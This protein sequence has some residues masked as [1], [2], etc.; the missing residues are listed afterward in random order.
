MS[1]TAPS[2]RPG[3][4]RRGRSKRIG[5]AIAFG[6][7][8]GVLLF[9]GST[10]MAEHWVILPKPSRD[11]LVLSRSLAALHHDARGRFQLTHILYGECRCSQRIFDYLFSSARPADV[12]DLVILVGGRDDQV[13]RGRAAG[14]DV[15]EVTP[16]ELKERFGI[17]SAP[18]LLIAD[19]HGQ[20]R[21]SGGYTGHKQGLDYRDL[22]LVQS[23]RARAEAEASEVPVYGCGVSEELQRALDPIGI[24]YDSRGPR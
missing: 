13:R 7:W 2:V 20:I 23:L 4:N 18:L 8:A 5:L 11:D 6:L 3:V 16:D 15:V 14:F 1:T 10:L 24:K 21:Y 12:D 9:I 22:E 17:V 19:A